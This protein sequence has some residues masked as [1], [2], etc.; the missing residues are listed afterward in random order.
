MQRLPL[1]EYETSEQHKDSNCIKKGPKPEGAI[2]LTLSATSISTLLLINNFNASMFAS[3]TAKFFHS[4]KRKMC[5]S[6]FPISVN[7]LS[8][9]YL[10]SDI[11]VLVLAF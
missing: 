4:D 2:G 1:E 10:I 6:G 11:W 5:T 9:T 7:A 8:V 3:E